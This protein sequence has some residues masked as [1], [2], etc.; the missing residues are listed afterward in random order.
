MAY[1]H[2]HNHADQ[3]YEKRDFPIISLGCNKCEYFVDKKPKGSITYER[4]LGTVSQDL[5][6]A[7]VINTDQNQIDFIRFGAGDDKCIRR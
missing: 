3:I 5:W 6:D 7:M 2:G 1:V 4:K